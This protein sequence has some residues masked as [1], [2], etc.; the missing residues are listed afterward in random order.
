MGG[1]EKHI[2]SILKVFDE[3]GYDVVIFWDEDLTKRIESSFSLKFANLKFLSNNFRKQSSFEKLRTLRSFDM[4]FYVTDGSYFFSSAKQN[5][6]FSMVPDKKLYSQNV[7]N[8]AKLWNYTFI[9]NSDFTR[10]WLNTWGMKSQTI[11]PYIDREFSKTT[12]DKKSKTILSVGRFFGHLHTKNHAQIIQTF[13]SLRKTLL[14]DFTLILAGG[15]KQDDQEYF[16]NLKKMVG[17]DSSIILKPN[18]SLS[19]LYRLY[20]LSTYYWHFTGFGVDENIHPEQV[21]HLGITPLEAMAAKC[22]AFCFNAGGPKEYI[23]D[24][25][26]GY[27]FN[28]EE[29]L[30]EKLQSIINDERKQKEISTKAQEFVTK[31]FSYDAFKQHVLSTINH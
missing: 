3:Q 23:K 20:R 13:K 15:L 29:E 16:N 22:I 2:L 9:S 14:K 24:D 18:V 17:D 8:K 30:E 10:H 12:T 26:N 27:L 6:V 19:E 21:E 28:N 31:H 5:F 1:G 25:E 7:I 11:H 4:F